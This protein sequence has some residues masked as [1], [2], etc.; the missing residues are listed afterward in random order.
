MRWGVRGSPVGRRVLITGAARGIGAGLAERLHARGARVGLIGLEPD[1][2]A[3]VAGRCGDAPWQGCDVSDPDD[4]RHAVDA[5]AGVLGGLD[6]VVANAGIARQW[7]VLHGD[8]AVFERTFAVNVLGVC[9]TVR[10]A[11]P[12]VGHP[13]GY[14]LVV[15]SAAAGIHLP[16]MGAYSA[17]KAAVE[18]IGNTARFELRP[19]GA[20]VGVA[21][22]A[23]LDTDMTSRGFDTEAARAFFGP[24]GTPGGVTP[25]PV[26]LEAV[27]R[28]IGRRAR[29]VCVPRWVAPLLL[30]RVPV[31]RALGL[32]VR[33]PRLHRA[34]TLA[35]GEDVP[36]TTAQPDGSR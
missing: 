24:G 3:E 6:V 27:E 7:S 36:F 25:L 14:V 2:L 23:E 11:A 30:A 17:S 34:L 5:V 19:A 4:V 22:F 31:Q 15:S 9:H 21:Y 13:G 26:A 32:R 1:A 29:A 18:A 16:L 28:A 10:A 8:M 12:H 35:A 33:G 20:R